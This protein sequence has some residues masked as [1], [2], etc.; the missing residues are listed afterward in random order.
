MNNKTGIA[1]G[2][3]VIVLIL[4]QFI[5]LNR[6]DQPSKPPTGIPASVLAV[7]EAHC[8][9][10]H[11]TQTRWPRSAWIAPLSWHVTGKVRQARK[12][13][14]FSNFDALPEPA[15]REIE[16]SAS[17]LAGSADLAKHGAIAGFPP[18]RMTE[19]ERRE[20]AEWA[21]NNNRE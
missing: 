14:D 13:L 20:L 3:I 17:R 8:Y 5:P 7:L 21:T 15:R 6:F 2:W 9:D 18:I 1:V 10:C 16:Q 19:S 11:S 4:I 12:A